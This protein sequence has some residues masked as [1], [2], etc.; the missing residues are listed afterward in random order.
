M[1][2]RARVCF[3]CACFCVWHKQIR[4]NSNVVRKRERILLIIIRAKFQRVFPTAVVKR[5]LFLLLWSINNGNQR[6][7]KKGKR[8]GKGDEIFFATLKNVEK[9]KCAGELIFEEEEEAIFF[10]VQNTTVRREMSF[11]LPPPPYTIDYVCMWR[12]RVVS[13]F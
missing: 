2:A 8:K 7:K 13:F 12:R 5:D 9:K 1:R 6:E 4:E 3:F 10:F 11:F